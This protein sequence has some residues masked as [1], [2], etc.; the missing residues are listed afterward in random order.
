MAPITSLAPEL[1]QRIL[2]FSKPPEH[3]NLALTCKT[4]HERLNYILRHSQECHQKYRALSDIEPSTIPNLVRAILVKQDWVAA[5]HIR[6]IEIWGSRQNFDDWKPYRLISPP[7]DENAG[8]D[9]TVDEEDDEDADVELYQE[10]YFSEQ[11]LALFKK[12]LVETLKIPEEFVDDEGDPCSVDGLVEDIKEGGVRFLAVLLMALAPRLEAIRFVRG[13]PSLE[14]TPTVLALAQCIKYGTYPA[15]VRVVPKTYEERNKERDER[16]KQSGVREEVDPDWQVGYEAEWKACRESV[17]L[18]DEIKSQWPAGFL[19]VKEI[20]VGLPS[21]AFSPKDDD[22]HE[23]SV[24]ERDQTNMTHIA[25]LVRLPC[26]ESLGVY[27][28]SD[29]SE[30]AANEPHGRWNLPTACSN[31][32][33]LVLDCPN[34]PQYQPVDALIE[35]CGKL[36][37]LTFIKGDIGQHVE[38]DLILSMCEIP[39]KG[40]GLKSILWCGTEVRGY[41]SSMF[42]P[43]ESNDFY[44]VLTICADDLILNALE[45]PSNDPPSDVTYSKRF[46]EYLSGLWESSDVEARVI[47]SVFTCTE[48]LFEQA[49][50]GSVRT[51]CWGE[52]WDRNL[53]DDCD[54]EGNLK[55]NAGS[56]DEDEKADA[57][58]G[59]E[60]DEEVEQDGGEE[61]NKTDVGEQPFPCGCL[62]SWEN[63]NQYPHFPNPVPALYLEDLDRWLTMSDPSEGEASQPPDAPNRNPTK[64]PFGDLIRLCKLWGV[65]VHTRTTPAPKVHNVPMPAIASEKDLET[66]PWYKHPDVEKLYFKPHRG[67]VDDCANCGECEECYKLHPAEC[68][69]KW[70]EDDARADEERK[71]REAEE[72]S[73][74]GAE[75]D[76]EDVE[77]EDDEDEEQ[78]GDEDEDEMEEDESD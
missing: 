63:H 30:E 45:G 13:H 58:S 75:D 61:E 1:I 24:P 49:L 44:P 48:E 16:E 26:L 6:A 35:A 7:G 28:F 67:M 62:P 40:W 69:A 59:T 37:H 46:A 41:R 42:S 36:E 50:I 65:E 34:Q 11:E 57:G 20:A 71:A 70:K 76:D 77:Q 12:A 31:I 52:C 66:S 54:E 73:D 32:R 39:R 15:P 33:N 27:G 72:G 68:W 22:D 25:P 74:E 38:C 53:N 64:R 51:V 60:D 10:G 9:L 18:P 2:E 56:D 55:E 14:W 47:I 43:E 78:W 3:L 19:S 4:L 5:W 29:G 17:E 23:E 8:P 21:R